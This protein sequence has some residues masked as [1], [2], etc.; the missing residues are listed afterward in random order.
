MFQGKNIGF[1]GAGA[2]AEAMLAGIFE[3]K[4]V[5]PEQIL[6]TNRSNQQ[7]LQQ[8]QQRYALPE[9]SLVREEVFRA[10]IVILATKPNDIPPLLEQWPASHP[11]RQLFISVAAGLSTQRIE[12][13][14][15]S[16]VGVVRAMPNTSSQVGESATALCRGSV[17]TEQ[18]M[19][20]AEHI[21]SAMGKVVRVEEQ[22]IDAV[23]GLS[24]SG[25]AYLYYIAEALEQAGVEVGLSAEEARLLTVQTFVGAAKMLSSS[26]KNAKTLREE[27]T[28]PNGTTMAGLEQLAQGDVA[29]LIGK[30]VK[31]AK[32]RSEEMGEE[33]EKN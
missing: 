18:H 28:S 26:G 33:L 24:G 16:P 3:Q 29:T 32:R 9:S 19:N 12:R 2:M 22:Q 23:T 21:F 27:V 5:K 4:L 14:F 31:A 6:V 25:P 10:D 17:A 8:L 30:A 15:R 11:E 20:L 1:I 13:C 7:R